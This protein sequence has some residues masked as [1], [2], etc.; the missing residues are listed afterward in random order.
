MFP[1]KQEST[2]FMYI[3]IRKNPAI[4][5]ISCGRAEF[6]MSLKE[7]SLI[8]TTDDDTLK[9]ILPMVFFQTYSLG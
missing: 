4:S 8:H 2:S 6:Q 5:H 9:I 3:V 1:F 7:N